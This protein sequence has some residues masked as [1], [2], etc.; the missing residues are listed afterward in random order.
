L[1]EGLS[2][3]VDQEQRCDRYNDQNKKE[4]YPDSIGP[5]YLIV[6][7]VPKNNRAR[8]LLRLF[9]MSVSH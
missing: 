3:L 2:E 1:I 6:G 9:A 4:G 5:V 8:P 7:S